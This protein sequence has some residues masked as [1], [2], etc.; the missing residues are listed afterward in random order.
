MTNETI[1]H[2]IGVDRKTRSH[3]FSPPGKRPADCAAVADPQVIPTLRR[4][5]GQIESCWLRGQTPTQPYKS[6]ICVGKAAP[7]F[8]A[9]VQPARR[10]SPTALHE[11]L[12][13]GVK[14][15]GQDKRRVQ[16]PLG[17]KPVKRHWGMASR[18]GAASHLHGAQRRHK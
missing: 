15:R 16:T 4:K 13:E 14:R 1:A 2:V 18:D 6:E 3:R 11:R 12:R 5:R 9:A 10:S 7:A 17:A 8:Q